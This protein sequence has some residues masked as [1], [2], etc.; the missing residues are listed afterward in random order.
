MIERVIKGLMDKGVLREPSEFEQ[1]SNDPVEPRATRSLA[2][3]VLVVGLDPDR[4][5]TSD[6]ADWAVRAALLVELRLEGRIA[7]EGTGKKAM[8]SVVDPH[9]LGDHELDRAL[10]RLNKGRAAKV[11]REAGLLPRAEDLVGRLLGEG[12]LVE[13]SSTRF[14][15]LTKRRLVPAPT[16][17][18][19]ALLDRVHSTLRTG[20]APD[21]RTALLVAVLDEL[22]P[23]RCFVA[24]SDIKASRRAG[25]AVVAQT[26]EDYRVLIDAVRSAREKDDSGGDISAV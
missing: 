11:V 7:V 4:G 8:V 12:L 17:G 20:R 10:R 14:G 18:R 24:A 15:M 6:G 16:A 22:V 23:Y 13:E 1:V 3:D 2:C 19:Q 9:A 26:H 21:E 25:E 5:R